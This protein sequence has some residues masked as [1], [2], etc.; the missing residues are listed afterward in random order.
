MPLSTRAGNSLIP[1]LLICSFCSNQ[2]SDY[3]RFAQIAQDKWAT[4]SELLRLLRGN[5][6][7]WGNHSG[8][9]EEM[10]DL[11]RITQIAQNKWA[12]LSDS[13]R[14]LRGNERMSTSLKKSK[15][16]FLVC[17]IYD[18]KKLLKKWPNHS[19]PLF[20]WAMWVNCSG[21]SPK[22]SDVSEWLR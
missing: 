2:M 21:R 14:S 16:L 22:M 20:W 17:F 9:S 3:E 11:E 5:K 13:F 15:I 19:F 4:L 8:C 1:S 10:S 18:K 6:R 7:P 12:T